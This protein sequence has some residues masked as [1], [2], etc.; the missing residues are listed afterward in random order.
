MGL[1][2]VFEHLDGLD[3]FGHGHDHGVGFVFDTVDALGD[4]GHF[5]EDQFVAQV[6]AFFDE[7]RPGHR[8]VL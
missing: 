6:H 8:R 1:P 2:R 4:F 7:R 3:V 5:G